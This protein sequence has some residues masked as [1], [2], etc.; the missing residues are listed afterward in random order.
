MLVLVLATLIIDAFV[1]L[2]TVALSRGRPLHHMGRDPYDYSPITMRLLIGL[3]LLGHFLLIV[4]F[5]RLSEPLLAGAS[6]ITGSVI[7]A[8]LLY[9]WSHHK[10]RLRSFRLYW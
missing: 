1:I 2:H 4:G 7:I 9:C 5:F 8:W 10:D 6:L 3:V